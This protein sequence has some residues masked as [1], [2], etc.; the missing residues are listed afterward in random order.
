[1]PGGANRPSSK[2]RVMP[3][4]IAADEA[5]IL[6]R[7]KNL[8]VGAAITDQNGGVTDAGAISAVTMLTDGLQS[9]VH[10]PPGLCQGAGADDRA[11]VVSRFDRLSAAGFGVTLET[12]ATVIAVAENTERAVH[13]EKLLPGGRRNRARPGSPR[14]WRAFISC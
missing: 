10:A 13:E 4:G 5:P 2:D 11:G 9:C 7:L 12:G 8:S 14:R 1:M 3:G 6:G